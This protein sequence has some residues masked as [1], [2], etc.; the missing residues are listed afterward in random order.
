VNGRVKSL[1]YDKEKILT[2]AIDRYGYMRV[3]LCINNKILNKQVHRLVAEAFIDNPDNKPQ[4]NHKDT[5]KKNN[6][7]DNLEWNTIIE[8]QQHA[9]EMGLKETVRK[10]CSTISKKRAKEVKQYDLQGNYIK[11]WNSTRE[12]E[13][14]L[15]IHHNSISA[16][17]KG[18]QKTAGE[19]I[20]KYKDT[21]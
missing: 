17:C 6:R 2:Q 11:T 3:C 19:Y 14:Q 18:K 10:Q 20:W 8:N 21:Q 16:C 1:K 12:I 4:V 7:V 13:R 15:K 5:N 9:W